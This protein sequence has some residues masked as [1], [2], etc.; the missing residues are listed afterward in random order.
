MS[1]SA[2]GRATTPGALAQ[3]VAGNQ[4]LGEQDFLNLLV[5]QLTNQDPLSP[6]DDQ[7]F[8]AQMAQ[9]ST[10]EGVNNLSGAMNQVQAASLIGKTIQYQT[11]DQSG[12]ITTSTGQVSAVQF[13]SGGPQLVVNGHAVSM[14]NVVQVSQ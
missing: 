5:T 2:I 14:A 7:Q 4:N 3:S 13:K 9:F 1:V 8:L 6:Q 12:N 10:V 11:A